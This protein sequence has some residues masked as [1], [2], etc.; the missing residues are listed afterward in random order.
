MKELMVMMATL[1]L[2]LMDAVPAFAASAVGGSVGF[3]DRDR[4]SSRSPSR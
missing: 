3:V 4:W 1:A 2:M